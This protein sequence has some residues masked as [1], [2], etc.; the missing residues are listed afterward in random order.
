M[1]KKKLVRGFT[2]IELM[3][4]VAI[5][6][7]LAAVAIPAFMD[8]M[9]KGKKTEAALQLNK[10]AK[11]AKVY[12]IENAA[13]PIAD[14]PLTPPEPC[15]AGPKA[16][17]PPAGAGWL[18]EAWTKLDFQID[19]PTLFQYRYHSDGKVLTAEAIGDLDCDGT[20]I[21][22]T[23]QVTSDARGNPTVTLTE[24]PPNSD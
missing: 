23:L 9:K 6:G 11:S 7:I 12:Y 1:L 16:K 4:V 14:A 21:T 19:E 22:Y 18:N 5:I 13:F 20:M 17:C 15:C 8:Y 10:L 3:I 2:L 24:P